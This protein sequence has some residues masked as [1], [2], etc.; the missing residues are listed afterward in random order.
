MPYCQTL[1]WQAVCRCG[2]FGPSGDDLIRVC[3]EAKAVGWDT[4]E[5][6]PVCPACV[7]SRRAEIQGSES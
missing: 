7:A 3:R 5:E 2:A 4:T 1:I 6:D